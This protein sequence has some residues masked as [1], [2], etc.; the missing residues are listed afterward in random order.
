MEK[1][2]FSEKSPLVQEPGDYTIVCNKC[3]FCY[4]PDQDLHYLQAVF[5]QDSQFWYW[6]NFKDGSYVVTDNTFTM[7]Q[8]NNIIN[9]AAECY[10][11]RKNNTRLDLHCSKSELAYSI[12]KLSKF[13]D[14][15]L[16]KAYEIV[17]IYGID[18]F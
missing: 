3:R 1:K 14:T 18:M 6:K 7:S 16:Q 8:Y 4:I 11:I 2:L 9:I 10:G 15:L 12:E 17:E 5:D 13:K